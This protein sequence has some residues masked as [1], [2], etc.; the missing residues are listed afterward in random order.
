MDL[1][2]RLLQRQGNKTQVEFARDLGMTQSTLSMFYSGERRL[3]PLSA[4][5]IA[6]IY[7][8]LEPAV[9]DYLLSDPERE[10]VETAA[11]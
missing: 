6:R 9:V 10:P 5:R 8:D 11:G 1:K 2:D 7:P 3:G 4:R